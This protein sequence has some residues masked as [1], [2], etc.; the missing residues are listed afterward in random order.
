[1]PGTGE[2]QQDVDVTDVTVADGVTEIKEKAFHLCK[3]LNNLSFLK[4][5]ITTVGS[6]AFAQSGIITL[7]GMEDV[8]KIGNWAFT[9]SRGPAHHRGLGLRG[10]GQGLLLALHLAAVDEG[11]A[12][13]HAGDPGELLHVLH[14]HD[15]RRLRPLARVVHRGRLLRPCFRRAAP[16]SSLPRSPPGTPTPAAVLAYLK[17]KSKDERTL[18]RYAIY[19]CVRRA[20]D[21]EEAPSDALLP[22]RARVRPGR[23][24][25]PDMNRAILE[26]EL[27]VVQR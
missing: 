7:L 5:S 2:F 15:R 10:D 11:V 21:Q 18:A 13:L 23:A 26:L 14:Q 3:G 25:P 19:A 16:R 4:D 1:M 9:N 6:S 8:R 20:R 22:D 17:R 27:G 24:A 12:Y